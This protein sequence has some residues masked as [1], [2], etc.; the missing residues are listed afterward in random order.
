MSIDS[1]KSP[2]EFVHMQDTKWTLHFWGFEGTLH[3]PWTR[4]KI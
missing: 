1:L 2:A 3:I 4:M